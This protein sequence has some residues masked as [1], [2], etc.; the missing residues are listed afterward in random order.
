MSSR[1][2]FDGAGIGLYIAAEI[3]GAHGG[4]VS[5]DSEPGKGSTFRLELPVEGPKPGGKA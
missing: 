4:T 3:M 2:S 5:V 1:R